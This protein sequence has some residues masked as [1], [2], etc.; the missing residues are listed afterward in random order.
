MSGV[1]KICYREMCLAEKSSMRPNPLTF[2]KSFP[3]FS[4]FT[5]TLLLTSR[6]VYRPSTDVNP[7]RHPGPATDAANR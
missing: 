1:L 2:M 4:G 7:V 6:Y 5:S 3:N